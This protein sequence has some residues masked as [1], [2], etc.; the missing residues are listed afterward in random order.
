MC[1]SSGENQTEEFAIIRG[2]PRWS[3]SF[4]EFTPRAARRS[5]F[6]R[7]PDD[8]RLEDQACG[9]G[10]DEQTK[11]FSPSGRGSPQ[12]QAEPNSPSSRN[13]EVDAET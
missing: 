5:S 3:G 11:V 2:I 12:S 10:M 8:L 13:D 1:A 6:I 9:H 7:W 4:E